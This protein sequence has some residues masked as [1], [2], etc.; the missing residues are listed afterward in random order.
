MPFQKCYIGG[1]LSFC[2]FLFIYLFYLWLCWVFAAVHGLSLVVASR[3][4]SLTAVPCGTRARGVQA[5]VVVV[6][7]FSCPATCG[8]LPDQGSDPC[9]L[10]W[11]ADSFQRIF[12]FNFYFFL[13]ALD[14]LW[15]WREGATLHCSAQASHCC[16]CSCCRAQA[17][18]TQVSADAHMGSGVAA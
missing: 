15:L 9:P 7:R 2:A 14:F 5:L 18:G 4:Y 12:N 17:P 3:V 6:H 10:H 16:G 8:T 13:A 1:F 11:Q